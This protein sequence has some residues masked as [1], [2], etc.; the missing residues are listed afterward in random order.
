M[1]FFCF[2]SGQVEVHTELK[3]VLTGAIAAAGYQLWGAEMVQSGRS[4]I[5]RVYIDTEKGVNI[6]DCE[7]ASRQISAVLE[8]EQP[9]LEN[10]TLEVSSPGLFRPLFTLAQYQRFLQE[11]IKLRL[12]RADALNRKNFSGILTKVDDLKITLLVDGEEFTFALED[13]SQ[14]HLNPKI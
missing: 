7:K 8:V 11:P 4:G 6:D 10:Y 3:N 5:L 9:S 14:A 12:K 13:V 1:G 2:W